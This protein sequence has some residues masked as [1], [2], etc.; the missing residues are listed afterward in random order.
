MASI[1]MMEDIVSKSF[2]R[3]KIFL[4]KFQIIPEMTQ[5]REIIEW[6]RKKFEPKIFVETGTFL[7]DTI[8]YFKNNFEKLIS[9]E[10]SEELARKATQR[11]FEDKHVKIIQGDSGVVLSSL[12]FEL[13][14]P[15]LFWLDGHYSS[16]FF[17]NG[18]FIQTAKN[19]KNTAINE[20]LDIILQS[21]VEAIILIDDARL[22]NGRNDYPTIKSIKKKVR[23]YKNNYTV[24]VKKDIIHIIPKTNEQFHKKDK[25]LFRTVSI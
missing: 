16:E 3:V 17:I 5:K 2:L 19:N 24:F 22:F 18:E 7:G 4:R 25:I 8:E 10:L 1:D 14:S 21:L 11:F 15:V 9:I 13:K 23:L 20:E 12:M 6:Y